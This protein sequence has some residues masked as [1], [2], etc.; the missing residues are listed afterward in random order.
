MPYR[1]SINNPKVFKITTKNDD[2]KEL[3]YR[4]EKDDDE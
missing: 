3:K 1:D 4:T 2:F